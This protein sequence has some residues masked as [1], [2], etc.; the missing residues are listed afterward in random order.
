MEETFIHPNAHVHP[1][2][3]IGE[4]C[5]VWANANILK[6]AKIGKCCTI[7]AGAEVSGTIGNYCKVESGAKVFLGVTAGHWVFFGPG[8]LTTNDIRPNAYTLDWSERFRETVI[9]N[10]ASIGAGAVIVC[11][12]VI[13]EYAEIGAGAVVTRNIEAG[14]LAVG[15]PARHVR[16]LCTVVDG[17]VGV[18]P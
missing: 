18:Q 7:G 4:G 10:C 5:K 16:K 11:G 8:A 9:G 17:E 2:A 14:W 13:G 12:V 15:V 1:Q 6:T 3:E